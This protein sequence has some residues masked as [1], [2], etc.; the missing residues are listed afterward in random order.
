MDVRARWLA[1]AAMILSLCARGV[2]GRVVFTARPVQQSLRGASRSP[3]SSRL[4]FCSDIGNGTVDSLCNAHREIPVGRQRTKVASA[5]YSSE[6][7][8]GWRLSSS[9]WSGSCSASTPAT[10]EAHLTISALA[11]AFRALNAA[12]LLVWMLAGLGYGLTR[13]RAHDESNSEPQPH[14]LSAARIIQRGC[15]A[16]AAALGG[17]SGDPPSAEPFLWR[18]VLA[19]GGRC[20]DT[21]GPG[22]APLPRSS[23]RRRRV[24]SAHLRTTCRSD[25]ARRGLDVYGVAP[26]CCLGVCPRHL[27]ACWIATSPR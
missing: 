7:R 14:G 3:S 11:Q 2:V 17:R 20:R 18:G 10:S 23:R 12:L 15:D 19:R 6:Y 4:A 21:R 13:A 5:N 8:P 27:S 25:C 16:Y 26:I 9:C 1:V 22:G 24:R